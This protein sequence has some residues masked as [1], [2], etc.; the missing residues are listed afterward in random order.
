ML[1]LRSHCIVTFP[2]LKSPLIPISK[3]VSHCYICACG[4]P[5]YIVDSSVQDRI[6]NDEKFIDGGGDGGDGDGDGDGDCERRRSRMHWSLRLKRGSWRSAP[7]CLNA[8]LNA[9]SSIVL[10]R[11]LSSHS[12]SHSLS[13][14]L[15]N[16]CCCLVD[17]L[18]T[19]LN[20]ANIHVTQIMMIEKHY[21]L[22]IM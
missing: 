22:E 3:T 13:S 5:R 12:M 9:D 14:F 6:E 16:I 21:L 17:A 1:I 10:R 8:Y 11:V 20:S 15:C 4:C 2:L 19:E 7:T 18:D